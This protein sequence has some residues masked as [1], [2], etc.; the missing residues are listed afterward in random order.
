ME[1]RNVKWY[2]KCKLELGANSKPWILFFNMNILV[3]MLVID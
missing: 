3:V 1:S 2:A